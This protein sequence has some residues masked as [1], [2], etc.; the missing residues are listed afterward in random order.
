M[1]LDAVLGHLGSL[2]AVH[3]Q[4]IAFEL[5]GRPEWDEREYRMWKMR[6]SRAR[7]QLRTLVDG[8]VAAAIVLPRRLWRWTTDRFTAESI[9][10]VGSLLP[11]VAAVVVVAVVTPMSSAPGPSGAVAAMVPA[12]GAD[13]AV[14]PAVHHAPVL[15]PAGGG[16][17]PAAHLPSGAPGAP[18]PSPRQPILGTPG[19]EKQAPEGTVTP[20][21]DD[22][23]RVCTKD[24]PVL[25]TGCPVSFNPWAPLEEPG[26][27]R[28]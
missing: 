28:P 24:Y 15:D 21:E 20:H 1:K 7:K 11:T 22:D 13:A 5:L 9:A 25:G 14:A 3:R 6:L 18:S 26:E 23:L 27:R 16:R 8:A 2:D 12:E 10:A 4:A 17:P 19:T